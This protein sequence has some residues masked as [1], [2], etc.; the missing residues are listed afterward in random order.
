MA[1]YL[2]LFETHAEYEQ[3]VS[4]D[5]EKPNVSHCE[6]QGDVHY[7][8]IVPKPDFTA[9]V[10]GSADGDD[11]PVGAKS[12]VWVE[13]KKDIAQDTT[14]DNGNQQL[15]VKRDPWG[16]MNISWKNVD[17]NEIFYVAMNG[18]NFPLVAGRYNITSSNQQPIDVTGW[19]NEF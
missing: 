2:K 1:K 9:I 12:V 16:A 4:G 5:F 8:P 18:V 15:S 17:T 11:Y 7:N 13:L 10:Y 3:Y 6:D 19:E 14:L